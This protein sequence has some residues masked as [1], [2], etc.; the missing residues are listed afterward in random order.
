MET[1]V[2]GAAA[3]AAGMDVV[4]PLD[5]RSLGYD[6]INKTRDYI[7]ALMA[8]VSELEEILTTPTPAEEAS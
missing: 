5:P 2:N 7:A 6:E 1:P 3:A 8:R 4:R